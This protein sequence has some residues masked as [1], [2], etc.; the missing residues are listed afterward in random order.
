MIRKG[1][2]GFNCGNLDGFKFKL[3]QLKE[4]VNK[5][6]NY[7]ILSVNKQELSNNYEEIKLL[8]KV[9]NEK[10]IVLINCSYGYSCSVSN[11][12]SWMDLK[13]IELK[14]DLKRK[15]NPIFEY[16][17]PEYLNL[18]IS[19]KDLSVLMKVEREQ[20]EYWGSKTKGE[21]IFNGYD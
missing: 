10:I 6:P 16:L 15:I 7:T 20:I 19:S 4:T 12:S 9:K 21:V 1:I 11:D 14:E 5:L 17:T 3:N 2:T 13:F 18:K 8:N